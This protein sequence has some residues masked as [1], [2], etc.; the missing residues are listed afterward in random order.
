MLRLQIVSSI[1][2]LERENAANDEA[3]R[4]CDA[5]IVR[6]RPMALV[7][8]KLYGERNFVNINLAEYP[9]DLT[10]YISKIYRHEERGGSIHLRT[11]MRKDLSIY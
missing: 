5:T 7:H 6:F 1:L 9:C 2:S 4:L 3:R 8:E 10:D 11:G